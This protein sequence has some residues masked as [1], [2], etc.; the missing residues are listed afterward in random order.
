MPYLI[1]GHNLIPKLGLRLD[2]LDDEDA[3][4]ARLQKF[5]LLRCVQAEV[6]F[7]GAPPGITTTHKAG[8]VTAH[9]VRL[10]SSADSAIEVRLARLGKQARNWTIVSSDRRVQVAGRAVHAEV[11]S[12]EEFARRMSAATEQASISTREA[13]LRPDEVDEWLSLFKAK[14]R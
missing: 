9:F 13:G 6:Y 12:S 8:A 11:L 2:S 14:K 3:L 5:C 4:L 1:D 7:D 10:G